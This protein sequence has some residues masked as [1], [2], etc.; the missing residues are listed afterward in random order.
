[1]DVKADVVVTKLLW[2]PKMGKAGVKDGV[3]V[4][5]AG[6][7]VLWLGLAIGKPVVVLFIVVIWD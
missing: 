4:I 2:V 5:G 3:G 7:G 6:G 1:M